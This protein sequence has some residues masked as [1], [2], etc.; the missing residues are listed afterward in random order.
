MNAFFYHIN[1]QD[2]I[3]IWVV[4]S[5]NSISSVEKPN[6]IDVNQ[7]AI[8]EGIEGSACVAYLECFSLQSTKL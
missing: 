1:Q 6:R 8:W 2:K 7:C 4:K 5:K 3:I